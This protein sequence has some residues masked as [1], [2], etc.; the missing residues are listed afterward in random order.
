MALAMSPA[1]SLP[2]AMTSAFVGRPVT[3]V[4]SPMQ[5]PNSSAIQSRSP[6]RAELLSSDCNA[7]SGDSLRSEI[8]SPTAHAPVPGLHLSKRSPTTLSASLLAVGPLDGAGVTVR[9]NDS[10]APKFTPEKAR[11]LRLR[12]KESEAHHDRMYH[13]G[14][15]SRLA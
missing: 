10:A 13:S 7:W 12:L 3:S 8:A 11:L 2:S 6:I 5:R 15:A 4:A 14:L 9:V 1:K